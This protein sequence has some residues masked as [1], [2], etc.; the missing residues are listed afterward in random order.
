MKKKI[1]NLKIKKITNFEIPF[2][3]SGV[4][5]YEGNIVLQYDSRLLNIWLQP[6]DDIEVTLTLKT[7]W[8]K[9][10]IFTIDLYICSPTQ[11]ID[12]YLD[13]VSLNVIEDYPY[14]GIYDAGATRF[15][16]I[17]PDFALQV[18]SN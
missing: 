13:G 10:G 4:L 12:E 18:S 14:P 16:N 5:K 11:I 9:P 8:L 17:L 15:G 6:K 3:V 1:Q 7:P 2:Y